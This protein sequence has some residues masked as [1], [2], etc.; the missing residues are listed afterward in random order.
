MKTT[1]KLYRP[2]FFATEERIIQWFEESIQNDTFIYISTD[3]LK[4]IGYHSEIPVNKIVNAV[5]ILRDKGFD[6]EFKQSYCAHGP[7]NSIILHD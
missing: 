5:H 7:F 1:E 2:E 4:V 3:K 6:V